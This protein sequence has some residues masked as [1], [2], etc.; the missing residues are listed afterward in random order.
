MHSIVIGLFVTLNI[1][2][3][4]FMFTKK[5]RFFLA[6]EK[7]L[8]EILFNLE[9]APENERASRALRNFVSDKF[10]KNQILNLLWKK[11]EQHLVVLDEFDDSRH[12]AG[13]DPESFINLENILSL[14]KNSF[15]SIPI[16]SAIPQ[17]LTSIGIIGTFSSI[18]I[19]LV[20]NQIDIDQTFIKSLVH[21]VAVGFASSII[22][23]LLAVW[24]LL[25]EKYKCNKISIYTD[26]INHHLTTFF[27]ILT[28]DGLLQKQIIGI[29]SLSRD[30]GTSISTGFAEMSGNL[31]PALADIIDD[32]TKKIVKDNVATSFIE[33]NSILKSLRD[34]S[35][36]LFEEMQELRKSK[37]EIYEAINAIKIDQSNLQNQINQQTASLSENLATLERT[38]APLR[39]VA[40][41]VEATNDL[42]SKLVSSVT[43]VGN[44]SKVI[45]EIVSQSSGLITEM[46]PHMKQLSDEYKGLATNIESWVTQSNISVQNN[47]K[48]FDSHIATV[49]ER[50]T[51][52]SNGL[53]TSVNRLDSTFQNFSSKLTMNKES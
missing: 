3:F 20:S 41:Q 21:A 44:A 9:R 37:S 33:M 16:W 14:S 46:K 22:G 53:N 32:D 47:L 18:F 52:L 43:E 8:E 28:T 23:V 31:G 25:Y 7:D 17:A 48:E 13:N 10:S 40:S 42:S 1:L 27:P 19:V 39:E 49:L 4:L 38:L 12:Y 2:L 26:S 5:R 15:L 35:K 45:Q 11:F 24:F 51:S 30:I 29:Q 6:L 36:N 34:E 50:A